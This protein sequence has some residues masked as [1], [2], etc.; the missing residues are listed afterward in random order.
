MFVLI[1]SGYMPDEIYENT[2]MKG[3]KVEFDFST[4]VFGQDS[5]VSDYNIRI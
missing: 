4:Y 5:F 3:K 2:S 1:G